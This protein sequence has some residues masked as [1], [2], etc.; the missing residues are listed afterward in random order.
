MPA[1]EPIKHLDAERLAALAIPV[2]DVVSRIEALIESQAAGR[3]W[4]A[5]KATFETPDGRYVMNTMAAATDPPILVVKSLVLNPRNPADGLP[6]MNAIITVQDAETGLALLT[7]DGNW[8]TAVRTA[9]LS[10]TAAR[11]L[12]RKEAGTIAFIGCGEQARHHLAAFADLFPLTTVVACGRGRANVDRLCQTAAGLGL[13]ARV[14][15][16]PRDALAEADLIVSSVT[17]DPAMA[18]FLD[19]AWIGEGAFAALTDLAEPW[20]PQGLNT[21]DS[22]V[23]DD[24]AQERAMSKKLVRPELVAGDLAGLVRG[25]IPGRRTPTERTAFIFRGHAL[26]DFAMASLV[27]DRAAG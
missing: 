22:I 27:Y 19:A 17:R 6:L 2:R 20:H 1:R 9:A 8:V 16:A 24:L 26:G 3:V 23:I 25:I 5:P 14:A 10:A 7:M 12:A 4:A 18:P 13:A 21:F 15:A 11:R